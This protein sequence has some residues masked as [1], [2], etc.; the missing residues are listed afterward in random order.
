[1]LQKLI[2]FAV[3]DRFLIL[4]FAIL[5]LVSGIYTFSHLDIEAYPDPSPPIIPNNA[6]GFRG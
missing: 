3:Y 1:M 2:D 6:F 4:V 5:V